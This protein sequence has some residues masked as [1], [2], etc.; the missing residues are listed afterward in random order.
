M[1]VFIG[2][3]KRDASGFRTKI[4]QGSTDLVTYSGRPQQLNLNAHS[5]K[6]TAMV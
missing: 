3:W 2:M 6:G 4:I 1:Q 5:G